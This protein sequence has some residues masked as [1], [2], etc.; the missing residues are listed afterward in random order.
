MAEKD[1]LFKN[2]FFAGVGA[3]A[4]GA[5]KTKEL[6]DKFVDQG[7]L[8]VEQGRQFNDELAQ[9]AEKA[10]RRPREDALEARMKAMT[11]EERD[12]FAR[13]AAEIAAVQNAAAKADADPVPADDPVA[14]EAEVIDDAADET[15]EA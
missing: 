6:V 12:E 11:P 13:K 4:I 10:T 7:Q 8:T 15:P 2:I 9:K 5:D 14:V 3:L 1:S